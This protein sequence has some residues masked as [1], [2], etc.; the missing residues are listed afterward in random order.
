MKS[1]SILIPYFNRKKFEKLIEYNINCQTYMNI[2]EVII[3]DDSTEPNQTLQLDIPYD[4][5]YLKC[6]RMTIGEKRNYLKKYANSDILVHMDSDDCYNPIY[7]QSVVDTLTTYNDCSITGS[8]DMLFIN[9]TTN[10]SGKQSCLF[11][12]LLNEATMAYTKEY[13]LTHHYAERNHSENETFT[14]EVWKIRETPIEEIMVC[15]CHGNNTVDKNVWQTDQY[16]SPL[17]KWFWKGN[18]Y[19]ILKNIFSKN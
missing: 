1:V 7:I 19:K 6:K 17:P 18:Y 5:R 12:N 3:A 16:K 11:L 4:L 10:W 2:K 9:M 13:A 14:T 15:V 8:A